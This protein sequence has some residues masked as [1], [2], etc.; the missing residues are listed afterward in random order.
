MSDPGL[1]LR[2]VTIKY[3]NGPDSVQA[4]RD[5]SLDL[6]EAEIVG[7]VGESGSGKS[8]IGYAVVGHLG[9]SGRVETGEIAFRGIDLLRL[10]RGAWRSIRGKRIAMVFQDPQ[11]ALNP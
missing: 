5:F 6:G 10:K 1:R 2:S 11:S 4:V 7:L 9:S 3:G 8:A